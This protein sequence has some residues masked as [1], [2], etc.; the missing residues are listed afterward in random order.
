MSAVEESTP[1]ITHS[2]RKLRGCSQPI[3]VQASDELFY[4]V[5]FS[6]NPQGANVLFNESI[7]TEL[8][9]ACNLPVP[10]WKP[11]LVTDTF[12]D[13][14]PRCWM[15][16]EHGLLRPDS[17]LCFGSRFL[18]LDCDRVLEILPKSFFDKV[19][20]HMDFWLAWLIDIC[21]GHTD[22]RQAI[23]L[24]RPTRELD[25]FFIDHGHLFR[26]PDGH[27]RMHF[28]K[29]R[30]LDPRIYQSLYPRD[31]Q[32]FQNAVKELNVDYVWQKAY[33]LP[34]DWKSKSAIDGLTECLNALS[35]SRLLEGILDMMVNSLLPSSQ[36]YWNMGYKPQFERMPSEPV[37]HLGVQSLARSQSSFAC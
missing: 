18:G 14:N 22:N 12:L 19:H 21:A 30:Y 34:A 10:E 17:G 26:G 25:A 27:G 9:R 8:Y 33:A 5:K 31:F 32:S 3:L 24:E 4:V 15:E 1:H 28:M 16:G 29:S 2:F 35:S 6:N 37:L 36:N 13:Q 20:N 23:F 7:G 11:L